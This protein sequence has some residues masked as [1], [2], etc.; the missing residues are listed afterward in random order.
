MDD[1][2]VDALAGWAAGAVSIAF[3]QPLDSLLVR[4]Q[5]QAN[6]TTSGLS[7]TALW[8]GCLPMMGAV[9]IQN[10]LLFS[11]YGAGVAWAS[12]SSNDTSDPPL[13][14]VFVGGCVGGFAQ[15]LLM[16]PVELVKVRLQLEGH[17]AVHRLVKTQ[18]VK[19]L[20]MGL[21]ATTLRDVIPHGV[22]F[23]TYEI[24]KRFGR[25]R[26]GIESVDQP[27]SVGSQLAA[28]G[29]A[30]TVAWLVGYPADIIKTRCQ[31]CGGGSIIDVSR[32][33]YYAGGMRIFYRGLNLK[34]VRAVPMSMVSFFVYEE[35]SRAL[36]KLVS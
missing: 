6:A 33:L 30:A 7:M 29:G 16:S 8:R 32:A 18:G 14:P 11:G 19:A 26:E 27:L 34:L 35:V 3:T 15:T 23:A 25:R 36:K 10:A 31:S 17:G 5:V 20:S 24:L 13:W 9:P 21:S 4:Q 28:G 1:R 2:V 22:W 12:G